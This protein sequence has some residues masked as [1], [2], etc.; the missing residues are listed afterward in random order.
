[1]VIRYLTLSEVLV[2]CHGVMKI[3]GGE[4]GVCDLV[5]LWSAL[6]QPW[7]TFWGACLYP[8][9]AAKAGALWEMRHVGKHG[10]LAWEGRNGLLWQSD[11]GRCG[12]GPE[13]A[14]AADAPV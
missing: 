7:V 5:A 3:G 8:G 9:L 2:L 13:S 11:G 10:S 14:P 4:E 1:M 12:L 6:A